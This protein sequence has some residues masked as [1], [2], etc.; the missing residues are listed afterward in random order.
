MKLLL[1]TH[2]LLWTIVNDKRL[3]LRA[4]R[5]IDDAENGIFY[6]VV[7]PWEVQIKHRLHPDK[8]RIGA[9]QLVEYCTA[10]G[11]QC[12]PVKAE[13]VY[14]LDELE[15]QPGVPAHKDP[16]D[17]MI[18]CQATAENMLLLTHDDRIAE[19]TAPCIIPV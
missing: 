13:H 1:D 16:F 9:K 14:S 7:S 3:S 15:R 17:R 12:V 8:L 19:Y 2:I 11:I 5:L 6:S 4:R 10:S 18:I